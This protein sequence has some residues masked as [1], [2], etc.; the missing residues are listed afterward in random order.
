MLHAR[1]LAAR[2]PTRLA[3]FSILALAA[4]WGAL[5]AAGHVNEFRDA[6]FLFA[7]QRVAVDTVRRFGQLPLWNPFYCGGMYALGALQEGFAS[8]PFLLGLVFGAARSQALIAYLMLVVGMEGG[9]RFLR[10][11]S[12]SALGP[13]L[14]APLTGL[15]GL[16]AASFFRG[17]L[18]VFT[19]AL[20]P[21]LL[22]GVQRAVRRDPWALIILPVTVAWMIGMGISY[23]PILGALF[24]VVELAWEL[25]RRH[26]DGRQLASRALWVGVAGVLA[27]ALAAV[28]LW[29]LADSMAQSQR[30]MAGAPGNSLDALGGALFMRA[31]PSGFNLLLPG[32]FFV[33]VRVLPLVFLGLVRLRL[34]PAA[35]VAAAS[36]WTATGYRY[37][38]GPFV[39]LR[40]LPGLAMTRYP[41]RFLFFACLYGSVLAAG[42]VD[43]ILVRCARRK[44]GKYRKYRSWAAL[45]ALA[46]F[47]ACYEPL[48]VNFHAVQAGM[49][50]APPPAEVDQPFA[51]ARGNRW[52]ALYWSPLGRGT[53]SCMEGYSLPQSQRLR[54]DLGQ[55]EHLADP[56]AGSVRRTYWSP[57]R[58]DLTV[59]LDRPGRLL[60]NQNWHAGWRASVGDVVS[61]EGLLAV[62]L[63]A[64]AH[65]VRLRFLP[66]SAIGGGAVSCAALAA[67]IVL[68]RRT[69]RGARLWGGRHTRVTLVCLVSPLLVAL[70][71]RALV[72][73]PAP[74]PFAAMNA[75][76]APL[77]A[78]ELP[79]GANHLQVDFRLPVQLL[80][81]T[82]PRTLDPA[83]IG[84]FELYWKVNGPVPRAVGVFVHL[85]SP[86]GRRIPAE[87]AVVGAST[88]FANAPRGRLLRD[89]FSV[90]LSRVEKGQWRVHAGLWNMT[91]DRRRIPIAAANGADT[92]DESVVVG[93]F[94]IE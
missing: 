91:G 70:M 53:L 66:R 67:M 7:Y 39:W 10:Q 62:D 21:W 50:L 4:L 34:L 11:R 27:L 55:E 65:E 92:H 13:A 48:I 71:V 35:I 75:N 47:A 68:F 42:A 28:R 22:H 74:P 20:V 69:R 9:Y 17:W 18:L 60:V 72:P 59:H 76:G 56:K 12:A 73:E 54:G 6:Q 78:D 23:A 94:T 1:C 81:S 25:A 33:G 49:W 83:G 85:E 77:V 58:I 89:A 31:R 86:T 3:F 36:V 30:V 2:T 16:Y 88:F 80:G 14:A 37:G 57:G 79:A 51:Q 87:H 32:T 63:P 44:S 29:P 45:A 46:L 41:E 84:D 93:T 40:E 24:C 52:L 82:L 8:P 43:V 38:A 61:D 26:R 15:G 90:D 5:G 19:F 64:G